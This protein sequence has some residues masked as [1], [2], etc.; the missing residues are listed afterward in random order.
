MSEQKR[1][2][3]LRMAVGF[4]SFMLW[5][6]S[7]RAVRNWLW[8]KVETKGKEKIIDARA[9]FEEKKGFLK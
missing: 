9:K 3:L 4:G 5:V 1:H 6:L 8:K 7:F 2:I